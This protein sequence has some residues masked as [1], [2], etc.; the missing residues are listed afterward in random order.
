MGEFT[1]FSNDGKKLGTVR[2]ASANNR[3]VYNISDV[4]RCLNINRTYATR[5]E[6]KYKLGKYLYA[7]WQSIVSLIRNMRFQSLLTV[8]ICQRLHPQV[9]PSALNIQFS[10]TPTVR[11]LETLD[12]Q[13]LVVIVDNLDRLVTEPQIFRTIVSD[14]VYRNL[15]N[16]RKFD[17]QSLLALPACHIAELVRSARVRLQ[18]QKETKEKSQ[19]GKPFAVDVK[20]GRSVVESI[21]I[22][23]HTEK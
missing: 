23:I 5:V 10:K 3:T 4:L 6:K 9:V 7:D 11:F 15:R 19:P 13:Q 12:D 16:L 1:M 18:E 17:L 2:Y 22:G 8:E 14:S 20:D 21:I